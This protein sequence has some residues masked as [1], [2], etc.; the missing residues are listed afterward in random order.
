ML[1]VVLAHFSSALKAL[2]VE[3]PVGGEYLFY[4]PGFELIH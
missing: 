4:P 1:L 3:D 2:A